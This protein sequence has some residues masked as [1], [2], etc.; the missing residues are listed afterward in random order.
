[1][2]SKSFTLIELL[3]V[4]VIIGILAGVI[5]ISTVSYI[6]KANLAKAQA[7]SGNVQNQILGN[8][9]SEWTFNNASDVE[10]DTWGNNEGTAHGSLILASKE[11]CLYGTCLSFDGAD[12]YIDLGGSSTLNPTNNMT[13]SLW[14]NRSN[15]DTS[16]MPLFSRWGPLAADYSYMLYILSN[17]AY[18]VVRSDLGVDRNVAGTTS[19]KQD[20]WYFIAFSFNGNEPRLYINGEMEGAFS[21]T[22]ISSIRQNETPT[23]MGKKG[24]SSTAWFNGLMDD[25]RFYDL[26]LP[27]SRVKQEYVAGLDSLMSRGL[28]SKQEYD[29]KI[30]ALALN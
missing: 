17:K 13:I 3:V 7:F 6:G 16:Q 19:I 27:S 25:V 20:T 26:A 4:I 2:K 9:V 18:V 8:L 28:I 12:D 1:M 11:N 5:T 24:D 21:G 23:L 15:E 30:E 10:E 14:I 29:Q 22:Q